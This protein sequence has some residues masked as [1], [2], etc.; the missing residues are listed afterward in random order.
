M[1]ISVVSII[2][3]GLLAIIGGI[4]GYQK[5]GSKISLLSG[6]IS[7]FLLI[8]SGLVIL[9]GQIWGSTLGITISSLLVIVFTFR[10]AKTRNLMPAGLMT[11]LG[12]IVL[13]LIINQLVS[14]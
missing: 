2:S 3:Y 11:I 12:L 6:V 8:I 13:A 4:I 7:G 10:F 14:A 1:I 5:A 9:Q